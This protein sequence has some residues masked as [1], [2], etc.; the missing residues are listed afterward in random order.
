[1]AAH[2][3]ALRDLEPIGLPELM[4]RA[5]LQTRVDRKY[6]LPLA[7]L[8]PVLANVNAGTRALE[9]AGQRTHRY[10]SVYFDTPDL[11][12][13]LQSARRRRRRFKLR[14]RTYL[15]SGQ[16]WLE[17]KTRDNRGRT[18]KQR[19]PYGLA[20]RS[21]LTELGEAFTAEVLAAADVPSPTAEFEPTLVT[22]Y[23]RSTLYLPDSGSR[24]T[25]DTRLAWLVDAGRHLETPGLAIVETK[26]GSTASSVDRLL[27]RHGHRPTSISKYATG[28]AALRPDLPATRWHRVLCHQLDQPGNRAA[29]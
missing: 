1:M 11:T 25:V 24:V 8:A 28:L 3:A 26:S 2:L 20:D 15:D 9:I 10:E 22:R 19:L 27:W 7:D 6:L 17:V 21:R 4:E 5:A 29:A 16:C 23:D 12:S 14:T 13:Y 18:V